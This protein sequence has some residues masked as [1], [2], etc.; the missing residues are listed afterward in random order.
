[1][2]RPPPAGVITPPPPPAKPLPPSPVA[3]APSPDCHRGQALATRAERLSEPSE[4]L[5]VLEQSVS[6]CDTQAPLLRDLAQAYLD[7]G[8]RSGARKALERA[9]AIDP[10][11][12]ATTEMLDALPH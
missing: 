6:L 2:V 11:D 3:A 7:V 12:S 9:Q 1:M 10:S 4:R 8:N 5:H